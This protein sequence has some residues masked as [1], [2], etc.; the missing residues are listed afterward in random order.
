MTTQHVL[1]GS[2][3]GDILQSEHVRFSSLI[4]TSPVGHLTHPAVTKAPAQLSAAQNQATAED[5]RNITQ[6][7]GI[8]ALRPG[9]SG[10]ENAPNR[11]NYDESQANPVPEYPEILKLNNY[12]ACHFSRD[13]VEGATP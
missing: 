2:S 10:N 11:A 5:H 6:Q 8:K 7:L 3:A 13:M 1:P 9:P 4:P 12:K